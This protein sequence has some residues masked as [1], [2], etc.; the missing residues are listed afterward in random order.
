MFLATVAADDGQ[1]HVNRV[2]QG[3]EEL[4][5]TIYHHLYQHASITC[6]RASRKGDILTIVNFSYSHQA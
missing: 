3:R 6:E 4:P 5:F 1:L 2:C